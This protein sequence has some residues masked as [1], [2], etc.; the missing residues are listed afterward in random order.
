LTVSFTKTTFIPLIENSF[1]SGWIPSRWYREFDDFFVIMSHYRLSTLWDVTIDNVPT[2]GCFFWN[3]IRPI[4]KTIKKGKTEHI[5]FPKD[6]K[7]IKR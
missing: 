4:G 1:K 7:W 3:L 5:L 6:L 2:S